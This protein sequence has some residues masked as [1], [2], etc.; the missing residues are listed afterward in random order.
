M[1]KNLSGRNKKIRAAIAL[2][3]WLVIRSENELYR[4]RRLETKATPVKPM[5]RSISVIPPSGK[6][7]GIAP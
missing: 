1:S 7:L 2:P 5:P 3:L 6:M 4:R